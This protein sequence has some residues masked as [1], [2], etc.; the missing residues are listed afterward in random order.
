VKIAEGMGVKGMKA[1]KPEEVRKT[2]EDALAYKGPVLV[3]FQIP[4]ED[5]VFPMVVPG[6]PL[7]KM[8]FEF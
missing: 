6:T 5:E 4:Q 2:L 3:D 1:S 8:L 7:D